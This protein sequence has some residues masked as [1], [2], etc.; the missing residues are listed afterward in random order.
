LGTTQCG[1]VTATLEALT[2]QAETSS[3]NL[4]S[5]VERVRPAVETVLGVGQHQNRDDIIRQTVRA[6]VRA[7]MDHLKHG[8]A[9]LESLVHSAGLHIVGAEYSLETGIVE[10]F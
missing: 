8:S 5:I 10:F 1:A 4:R 3:S 7:S 6:N 9:V 2:G